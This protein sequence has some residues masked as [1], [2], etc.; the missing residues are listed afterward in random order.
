MNLTIKMYVGPFK[1][2]V[3]LVCI[4]VYNCENSPY[5]S[6]KSVLILDLFQ[7]NTKKKKIHTEDNVRGCTY[8]RNVERSKESSGVLGPLRSYSVLKSSVMELQC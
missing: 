1:I 8:E 6:K 7:A 5:I 2:F 3:L 4:V